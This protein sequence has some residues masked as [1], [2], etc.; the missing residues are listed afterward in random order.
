[1]NGGGLRKSHAPGKPKLSCSGSDFE[2]Q[3]PSGA[4]RDRNGK[5][6]VTK[7]DPET[8]NPLEYLDFY[9]AFP[10]VGWGS[11][12]VFWCKGFNG[13]VFAARDAI[14][15][16]TTAGCVAPRAAAYSV[17][18]TVRNFK[19]GKVSRL[20]VLCERAFQSQRDTSHSFSSLADTVR[21]DNYPSGD[22]RK[23][24]YR[25]D[26]MVPMSAT[27][28]HELYHL[29][30]EDDTKDL[31]CKWTLESLPTKGFRPER[32]SYIALHGF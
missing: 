4:V 18:G 9:S 25:L 21:S 20:M 24:E 31:S 27:F 16:G 3:D 14:C 13:Y 8:K 11:Q 10:S 26:R 7:K 15:G 2:L 1:M 19:L 29:T 23:P 17:P 32:R 22:L 6:V 12:R 28:Y 5:Y 30:D